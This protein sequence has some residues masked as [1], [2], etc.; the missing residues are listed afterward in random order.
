M[1]IIKTIFNKVCLLT[2][3]IFSDERGSFMNL[4]IQK[5]STA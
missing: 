4:I 2:P 3:E 1:K 5:V